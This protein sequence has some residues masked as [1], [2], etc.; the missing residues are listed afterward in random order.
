LESSITPVALG[1]LTPGTTVYTWHGVCSKYVVE[2]HSSKFVSIWFEV[3]CEITTQAPSPR[4]F[5]V[6]Y[7]TIRTFSRHE[8]SEIS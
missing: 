5:A 3:A 6:G 8:L 4:L 2:D 7:I 1:L